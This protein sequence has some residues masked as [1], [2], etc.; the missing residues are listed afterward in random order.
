MSIPLKNFQYKISLGQNFIFDEH[1]LAALVKQPPLESGD[2][3][4]EIGA[5][6]GDLT[7]MLAKKV[8][9]VITI[10]IDDRLEKVL[11]D[12]FTNL[13]N[14]R[15]VMGDVMKID[16]TALMEPCGAFHV[17]ANLPY[18]LTTP[19]LSL[20]FRLS[21]P[22]LSVSVM[23]Q[24]EAAQRVLAKPGTPEYGPLAVMAALRGTPYE[25]IHVPAA[26]FT[27]PPKV[28]S[29]FLVMP[30]AENPLLK[31]GEFAMFERVVDSAFSMRRKTLLNNLMKT[32]S[33]S[34]QQA[35]HCLSALG[36][37]EKARGETLD[38]NQF[39]ALYKHLK[40]IM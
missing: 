20:L 38:L 1:L 3:V 16:L 14:I 12:R 36:I 10:E 40:T 5:G 6:R 4:L 33:V 35:S 37:D 18:Y 22:I 30:F 15:L 24:K 9:Q 17:V 19:I 29:V 7:L 39:I 26:C 2:T 21:L 31:A 11:Q 8:R 34:R 23:V 13:D 27:P 32:F 28:D 25:T